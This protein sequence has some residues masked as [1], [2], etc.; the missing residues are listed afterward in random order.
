MKKWALFIESRESARSHHSREDGSSNQN[1]FA[2]SFANL[3]A[4]CADP[5]G[6]RRR[7]QGVNTIAA[8]T[9]I[10]STSN[11]TPSSVGYSSS[12]TGLSLS[13]R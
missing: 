13:G 10:L 2:R 1:P 4:P 12:T 9:P 11:P 5:F 8:L 6:P 7:A 3:R